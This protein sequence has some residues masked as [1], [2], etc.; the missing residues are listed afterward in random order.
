MQVQNELIGEN[1]RLQE[2]IDELGADVYLLRQENTDLSTKQEQ[3][4][5]VRNSCALRKLLALWPWS[6]STIGR[7]IRRHLSRKLFVLC[8]LYRLDRAA[9]PDVFV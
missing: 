3:L 7:H 9:S 2:R 8:L 4:D 5:E 1:E 6:S